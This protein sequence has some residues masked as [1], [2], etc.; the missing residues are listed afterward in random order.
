MAF[1]LLSS[2]NNCLNRLLDADVDNT[3]AVVREDDVYQ[4]LSDIVDISRYGGK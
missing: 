3:V 2:V 4:I 1:M